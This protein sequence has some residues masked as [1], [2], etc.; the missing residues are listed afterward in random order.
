MNIRKF[1]D[2][3]LVSLIEF[4]TSVFSKRDRVE[5]SIIYRFFKHPYIGKI[6][7]QIFIAEDSNKKMVGQ[8]LVLPSEF[9]VGGKTYPAFWGMD[10]F[11]NSENRHSLTGV[12]LVNKLKEIKYFFGLGLTDTSLAIL[13]AFKYKIIGYMPK[14]I[15]I[16]NIFSLLSCF[17]S[18]K[19]K[20]LRNYI[21]PDSI[22]INEKEFVRVYDSQ[23]I[24]S[25]D[26]YWNKNLI[27]FTRSKDFI[28]WRYFYYP[29]KY[30]VYK[31][32]C[33]LNS[34]PTFF[35]VRTILWKKLNCLLLVDYR[36]DTTDNKIF[37]QVLK[38]TVKLAKRLKMSAT[39]IGCSLPSHELSLRKKWFF[40]F[41]RSMEIVT[42]FQAGNTSNNSQADNV[43]VT[44]A[45]SDCDFYYGSDKW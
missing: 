12:I 40:K 44:F 19:S 14:Y 36:F 31:F 41:G 7:N 16:N 34:K 20:P 45:D 8:I 10:F 18:F 29:D 43:F 3:D 4:N 35:V 9:I 2:K 28:D 26:G 6:E 13:T 32:I 33:D 23:E 15:R 24:I 22:K 25:K 11:V 39:I 27:E 42:K 37:T 21:F 38:A 5:E 1:E 30:I 17:L